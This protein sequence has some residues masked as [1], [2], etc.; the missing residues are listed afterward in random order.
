LKVKNVS[1]QERW[2]WTG[3]SDSGAFQWTEQDGVLIEGDPYVAARELEAI[4]RTRATYEAT[5][6]AEFISVAREKNVNVNIQSVGVTCEMVKSEEQVSCYWVS[7]GLHQRCNHT[8]PFYMKITGIVNFTSDQPWTGAS[9]TAIALYILTN[10]A[11]KLI[12][13]IGVAWGIYVFLSTFALHETTSEITET[14]TDSEG[15]VHTRTE[16]KKE[17]GPDIGALIVIAV[18]GIGG[19]IVLPTILEGLKGRGKKK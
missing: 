16:K 6:L 3:E 14:W 18:L 9:L 1:Y 2:T 13:A 11:W 7:G 4:N 17:T 8:L 5:I 10:V 12:I 15:N 19:L